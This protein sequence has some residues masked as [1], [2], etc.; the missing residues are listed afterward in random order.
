LRQIHKL[1]VVTPQGIRTYACFCTARI[2]VVLRYLAGTF[3][4][5]E[6][7]QHQA[8]EQQ[9]EFIPLAHACLLARVNRGRLLN[10]VQDGEIEAELRNGRDKYWV[11][12]RS[13]Q[14]YLARRSE[15][16]KREAAALAGVNRG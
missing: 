13:V 16:L 7:C 15:V 6:R 9:D 8:V 14:A 4:G 5:S 3:Q 2:Y 1:F 11:S 12:R 10:A